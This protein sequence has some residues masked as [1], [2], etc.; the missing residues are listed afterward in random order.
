[1][2]PVGK[3][4]LS[5]LEILVAS[6]LMLGCSLPLLE[7]LGVGF[8]TTRS[9]IQEV[10]GSN[11]ATEI[12]EQVEILPFEVARA[13]AAYE[14]AHPSSRRSREGLE[15]GQRLA[16]GDLR[17]HLSPLPR[18][19]SRGITFVEID[20]STVIASIRVSWTFDGTRSRE[21]LLRRCLVR[22]SLRPP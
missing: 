16:G 13:V 4:G 17:F 18:N 5:L 21:I 11:L 6:V 15:D 8:R 10:V 7:L 9:T 2:K 22:D 19:F 12:A 1:M 14:I 20:R 3:N